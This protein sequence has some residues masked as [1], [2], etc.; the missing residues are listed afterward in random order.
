MKREHLERGKE[1]GSLGFRNLESMNSVHLAKQF[2]RLLTKPNQLM[3]RTLLARYFP[4]DSL[5]EVSLRSRPPFVWRYIW[6]ARKVI[7]AGVERNEANGTFVW[8][9]DGSLTYTTK[10]RYKIS[11]EI[12]DSFQGEQSDVHKFWNKIWKLKVPSKLKFFC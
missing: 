4:N 12:T 3:S 10:S 2:W 11:Q 9:R 5:L 8:I 7:L 6:G 1:L